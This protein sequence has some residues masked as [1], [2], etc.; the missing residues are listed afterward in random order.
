LNLLDLKGRWSPHIYLQEDPRFPRA[1]RPDAALSLTCYG[2]GSGNRRGQ[3]YNRYNIRY[4]ILY[5]IILYY[6][7]DIIHSHYIKI[8]DSW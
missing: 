3:V 8:Q 4:I 1:E 5:Y 7:I 6:I 2:E